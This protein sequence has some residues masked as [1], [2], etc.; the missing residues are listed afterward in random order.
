MNVLLHVGEV[1]FD[2]VFKV[3]V[4]LTLDNFFQFTTVFLVLCTAARCLGGSIF[5]MMDKFYQIVNYCE[6][7]GEHG[8]WVKILELI[9]RFGVFPLNVTED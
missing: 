1:V 4:N 5:Q 6:G 2:G 9:E 8:S 7:R 3:E